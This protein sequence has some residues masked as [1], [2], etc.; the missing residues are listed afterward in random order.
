MGAGLWSKVS[1]RGS[2]SGSHD[3]SGLPHEA[4][5]LTVSPR[6]PA[7]YGCVPAARDTPARRLL[8]PALPLVLLLLLLH[9][10]TQTASPDDLLYIWLVLLNQY[11][12]PVPMVANT[13]KVSQ[14]GHWGLGF[15]TALKP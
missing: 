13:T 7:L 6:T 14:L 3:N 5:L 10:H 2:K 4:C 1:R 8:P 9:H 15:E 12:T 11:V